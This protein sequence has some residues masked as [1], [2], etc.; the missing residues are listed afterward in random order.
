MPAD[1]WF[2]LE[3]KETAV[4]AKFSRKK[5]KDGTTHLVTYQGEAL[6]VFLYS[7]GISPKWRNLFL[8]LNQLAGEHELT[9]GMQVIIPKEKRRDKFVQ[10]VDS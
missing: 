10:H 9:P 8:K 2:L 6:S 7:N 5:N 3:K 1:E 4:V